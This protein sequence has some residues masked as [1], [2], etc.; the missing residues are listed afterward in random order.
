L[1]G[2]LPR[3]LM[4]VDSGFKMTATTKGQAPL[5]FLTTYWWA[6]IAIFLLISVLGYFGILSPS[7]IL[8]DR[9]NIDPNI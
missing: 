1:I 2:P 7:K 6:L 9:C 3:I 8:P 5:E 4:V